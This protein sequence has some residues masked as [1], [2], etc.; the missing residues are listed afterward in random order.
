MPIKMPKLALHICFFLFSLTFII[1]ISIASNPEILVSNFGYIR[2]H[3]HHH[4]GR[5][6]D[7]HKIGVYE[8]NKGNFSIKLTNYG[9]TVMSVILPDK[10]GEIPGY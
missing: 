7:E 2:R 10:Y 6:S 3:S 9:A 1:S 4:R 5:T 8:L